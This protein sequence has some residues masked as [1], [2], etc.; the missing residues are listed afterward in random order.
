M[1][2][3]YNKKEIDPYRGKVRATRAGTGEGQVVGF[4]GM[5]RRREG[6]VFQLPKGCAFSD[7][8]MEKV[9][10]DATTPERKEEPRRPVA[11]SLIQKNKVTLTEMAQERGIAIEDTDTKNDIIEKISSYEED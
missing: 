6:E 3:K 7:K 1:G 4:D 11:T 10:Q 2:L 9:G 5:K 8:W